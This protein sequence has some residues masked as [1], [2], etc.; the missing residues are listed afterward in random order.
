MHQMQEYYERL[1]QKAK[2]ELYVLREQLEGTHQKMLRTRNWYE[3]K[4]MEVE[5]LK[6]QLTS[7]KMC[8]ENAQGGHHW[9]EEE[10]QHL[11]DETKFLKRRLDIE[12]RKS[13]NYELQRDLQDYNLCEATTPPSQLSRHSLTSSTHSSLLNESYLECPGCHAEYPASRYRELMNH[14]EVCLD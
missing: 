3:E 9:S 11:R 12:R 5:E 6:Q 4:A 14:L 13:A 7:A 1:L 10:E 8:N 2:D